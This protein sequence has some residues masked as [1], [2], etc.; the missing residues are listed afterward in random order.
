MLDLGRAAAS[1]VAL[2]PNREPPEHVSDRFEQVKEPADVV[3]AMVAR[4]RDA[5]GAVDPPRP[6]TPNGYHLAARR[7][8]IALT[9]SSIRSQACARDCFGI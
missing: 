8:G 1:G 3:F 2:G 5:P 6:D 9:N 7:D 4:S